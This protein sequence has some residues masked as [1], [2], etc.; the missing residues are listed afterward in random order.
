MESNHEI[1]SRNEINFNFDKILS[2]FGD[3]KMDLVQ[4]NNSIFHGTVK[5]HLERLKSEKKTYSDITSFNKNGE[6][7][8]WVHFVQEGGGTLGISLVG[9]AFVLEFLGIRFLRLAGTSAGAINTL[10]LAAIGEKDD[11]KTPELFDMLTNPS[12]FDMRSFIDAKNTIVRKMILSLSKGYGLIKNILLRYVF[13]LFAI[14]F[15]LPLLSHIGKVWFIVYG[16]L[17]GIFVLASLYMV[18]LFYRFNQYN[19][20]INPGTKFQEFLEKELE[21]FGVESQEHLDEKAKG[22]TQFQ[23]NPES[24]YRSNVSQNL[25]PDATA[26]L[27]QE[28]QVDQ[29]VENLDEVKK[30]SKLTLYLNVENKLE[31][32]QLPDEYGEIAWDYSFVATDINNETKV[33]LPLDGRLYFENQKNINPSNYVRASMAI[34]IFFEPQFFPEKP[35]KNHPGKNIPEQLKELWEEFKAK[36]K[37]KVRDKGILID[38]GSLSNFPINLFHN[39]KISGKEPRMPIMGVRIMDEDPEEKIPITKKMSFTGFAGKI[40]NTLRNNEDNSFLAINPFYK[41]YSIAD[42]SAY[43]TK[44][45]WLNFGLSEAEQKALFLVGIKAALTYL[46]NFDWE[47]YKKERSKI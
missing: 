13:L 20:G 43:E 36:P 15:P 7:L 26:D 47:T 30:K 45:N 6:K 29:P 10:F 34:P 2:V 40:I 27:V 42:I 14:I 22:K 11:P 37:Y 9:Y 39:P 3:E 21:S 16:S 19:F 31:G 28:V 5:E 18:Y 44:V 41:K 12:R 4:P 38:G 1:K 17:L 25:E 33:V 24:T 23:F 35:T 8:H 32:N 46:E